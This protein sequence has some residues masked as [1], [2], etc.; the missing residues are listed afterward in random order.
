MLVLENLDRTL[1]R[2][3]IQHYQIPFPIYYV[4]HMDSDTGEWHIKKI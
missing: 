1:F 4:T 2:S 3:D